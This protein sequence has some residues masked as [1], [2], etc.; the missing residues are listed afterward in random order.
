MFVVHL[1]SLEAVHSLQATSAME[2][3]SGGVSTRAITLLPNSS[4]KLL[5]PNFH[6]HWVIPCAPTESSLILSPSLLLLVATS[7]IQV[8]NRAPLCM[9]SGI[10]RLGFLNRSE[11]WLTSHKGAGLKHY[12]PSTIHWTWRWTSEPSDSLMFTIFIMNSIPSSAPVMSCQRSLKV[13][14]SL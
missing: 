6:R 9:E 14:L 11:S 7:S 1:R 2:E 5:P 12:S 8:F 13:A 3:V 10:R 4:S